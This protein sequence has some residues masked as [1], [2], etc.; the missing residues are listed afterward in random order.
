MDS[1]PDWISDRIGFGEQINRSVASLDECY[2][3]ASFERSRSQPISSATPIAEGPN[4]R[5]AVIPKQHTVA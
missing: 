2:T 1:D 5:H 4:E 3:L